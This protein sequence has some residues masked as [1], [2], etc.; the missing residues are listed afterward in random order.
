MIATNL[1][2]A[3]E[4]FKTNSEPLTLQKDSV[5]TSVNSY[6]EAILFFYPAPERKE[7]ESL[8][9]EPTL[10]DN[11]ERNNTPRKR[12]ELTQEQIEWIENE[13]RTNPDLILFRSDTD[14]FVDLSDYLLD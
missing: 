13:Y 11:L 3:K 8:L 7:S 12:K 5:F 4:W 1:E 6:D 10:N 14:D 2:Q 9:N